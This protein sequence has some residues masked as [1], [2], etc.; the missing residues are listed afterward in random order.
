MFFGQW[1]MVNGL[2]AEADGEWSIVNGLDGDADGD[3]LNLLMGYA[4]QLSQNLF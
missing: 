3:G 4:K 2:D 1:L